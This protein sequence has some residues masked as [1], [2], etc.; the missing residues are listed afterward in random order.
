MKKD[1]IQYLSAWPMPPTKFIDNQELV[2][3]MK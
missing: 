2:T 3:N 1:D